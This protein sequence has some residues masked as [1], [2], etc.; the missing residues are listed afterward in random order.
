MDRGQSPSL[1]VA[2]GPAGSRRFAQRAFELASSA[3]PRPPTVALGAA[4]AT[5][6]LINSMNWA[7][8]D[9]R[10]SVAIC[11][12]S[13]VATTGLAAGWAWEPDELARWTFRSLAA[14][15]ASAAPTLLG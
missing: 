5:A 14:A 12:S 10:V 4:V 8:A 2:L 3:R 7:F 11:A 9:A 13:L 15:F 1:R 6:W